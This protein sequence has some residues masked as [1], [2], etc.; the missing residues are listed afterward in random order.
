MIFTPPLKKGI[1]I[2]RYKRFLADIVLDD[3]QEITAHC[4]NPGAML[5]IT[6]PGSEVF[7]SYH[8]TK[9]RKLP[10]TWEIVHVDETLIGVNT[11]NPNRLVY[12]ALKDN[13]ITPLSD[14]AIIQKEINYGTNSRIDFF[15]KDGP[16][17]LCYVEVKNVHLIRNKGIAEF[18]DCVT[19]RGSRH[20]CELTLLASQGIRTVFIYIVQR[21]DCQYFKLA[22]DLDPTYAKNALQAYKA[23][24]EFYAYNC[25]VT[26]QSIT[27]NEPLKLCW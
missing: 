27:I 3:G 23:G 14:Y 1:L 16:T 17:P 20:L 13:I 6:T 24:V 15:L 12:T 26:P 18:P 7:V 10:F 11:M 25:L 22:S 21:H 8:E 9:K 5:G 2:K 19:T 4:S